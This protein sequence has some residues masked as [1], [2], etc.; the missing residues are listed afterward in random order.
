MFFLSCLYNHKM[1]GEMFQKF[2]FWLS[3][4]LLV[5][6]KLR[7]EAG[8]QAKQEL[9]I[10]HFVLKPIKC[11]AW[12]KETLERLPAHLRNQEAYS[13]CCIREEEVWRLP[14]MQ[15]P[16]WVIL[17]NSLN[18]IGI[19]LNFTDKE[20]HPCFAISR[21]GPWDSNMLFLEI[22]LNN[23]YLCKNDTLETCLTLW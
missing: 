1:A 8:A 2:W 23:K 9:F 7:L 20:T 22:L 10:I 15:L 19:I 21:S 12:P 18:W 17:S 14:D 6:M 4:Q 3:N 11:A 16:S 13:Q 5:G